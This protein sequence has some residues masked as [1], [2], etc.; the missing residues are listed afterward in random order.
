MIAIITWARKVIGKHRH[1]ESFQEK[2]D[3]MLQQVKSFKDLFTELFQ[4]GL[5]SFWDGYGKLISQS[6]YQALLVKA[7][8]DQ[9]KFK[10]M[11]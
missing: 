6:E 2:D 9:K 10:D 4:K 7:R 11:T 5:P 1:I 8:L 3:N